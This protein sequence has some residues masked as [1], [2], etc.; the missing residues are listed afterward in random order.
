MK[1]DH[2]RSRG[3][4]SNYTK[5]DLMIEVHRCPKCGRQHS[6]LPDFLV[7]YKRYSVESIC[8]I[9]KTPYKEAETGASTKS[10]MMRWLGWFLVL[11]AERLE[12]FEQIGVAECTVEELAARL[13]AASGEGKWLFGEY[14]M[15]A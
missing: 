12:D 13:C 7:A 4:V 10:R 3:Y 9:V 15:S 6:I 11:V 1:F 2:F 8:K 5:H 14:E